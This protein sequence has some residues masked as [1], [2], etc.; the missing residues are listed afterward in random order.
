MTAAPIEIGRVRNSSMVP[1][2]RSSAHSRMASAGI[3][4]R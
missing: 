2:L 3:S 4:T 1:I